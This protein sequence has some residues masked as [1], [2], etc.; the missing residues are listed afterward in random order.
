MHGG[1][2]AVD[3]SKGA[4]SRNAIGIDVNKSTNGDGKAH[5]FETAWTVKAG[6]GGGTVTRLKGN[7]E[8]ESPFLWQ[9][10]TD[11]PV[12]NLVSLTGADMFVETDCNSSG[13][14]GGSEPHL[15]IY[16]SSCPSK[17]FDLVRQQCR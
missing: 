10:G 4:V 13:C 12:P 15:M 5:T 6:T 2:I 8:H 14:S 9:A 7:G 11:V 3:A 16:S 17:W 1:I